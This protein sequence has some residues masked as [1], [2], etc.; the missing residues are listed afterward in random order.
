M[1]VNHITCG[2]CGHRLLFHYRYNDVNK[3]SRYS[4]CDLRVEL[5]Q[6]NNSCPKWCPLKNNKQD[7]DK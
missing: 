3:N 4:R 1:C 7:G 5:K 2:E 6:R